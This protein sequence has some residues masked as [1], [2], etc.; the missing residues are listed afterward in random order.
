MKKVLVVDDNKLVGKLVAIYFG[1]F[2]W[3]VECSEGPFGVLNKV[4]LFKP[5]TILLDIN[6]PGLN[7]DKL[8]ALIRDKSFEHEFKVV[9]FS[10]EDEQTQKELVRKGLV[11]AYFVKSN[12]LEGLED[13]VGWVTDRDTAWKASCGR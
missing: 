6:M 3:E 5:D 12:S 13:V 10:A 11:D 8:A 1:R 4:K 2:G 7:G 9:S